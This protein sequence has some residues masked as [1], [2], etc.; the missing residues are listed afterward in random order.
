MAD[1]TPRGQ[2][3]FSYSHKDKK[4]LELFQATLKP[5]IRANQLSVWDDTQIKAGD[6]W[7]DE[8]KQALTSARVAVLLVSTNFLNSDFIAENELPP[9]LAAA[10]NEGLRILLVVVGHSLF[11]ETELGR[12]Q[13]VNDP[14]RPLASVSAST[15]EKEIVRICKE[16]KSAAL[17]TTRDLKAEENIKPSYMTPDSL[18][19]RAKLSPRNTIKEEWDKVESLIAQ[20]G[21]SYGL[22]DEDSSDIINELYEAEK[23]SKEAREAFFSLKKW[24]YNVTFS[25]QLPVEPAEA[26]SFARWAEE[27]QQELNDSFRSASR[28]PHRPV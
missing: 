25:P 1:H 11:E 24:E 17:E 14:S 15:R 13:A 6:I 2:V 3:F 5:F 20:V 28:A 12:Y 23:I 22:V 26:I 27:L 4:W 19:E 18:E 8:I 21:K 10:Q 16:I 9:L 7:R